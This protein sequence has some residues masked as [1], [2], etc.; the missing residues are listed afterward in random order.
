[1]HPRTL[2]Q[3]RA[4]P[5]RASGDERHRRC[6]ARQSTSRRED[7]DGL[8]HAALRGLK[9]RR[10]RLAVKAHRYEIRRLLR[11][12]SATA[13]AASAAGPRH[14]LDIHSA[15]GAAT[16][17]AAEAARSVV[18]DASPTAA[19]AAASPKRKELALRSLRDTIRER[20]GPR[21]HHRFHDGID[22]ARICNEA[23]PRHRRTTIS[24]NQ[25]SRPRK[26][27][28]SSWC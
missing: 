15:R 2:P 1:M 8:L 9:N 13:S 22:V 18:A 26:L 19:T 5:P 21:A 4:P 20:D 25:G 7:G 11:P 23:E 27:A 17:S 16:S 12:P 24:Q 3:R 14:L 6:E 28:Y 10:D